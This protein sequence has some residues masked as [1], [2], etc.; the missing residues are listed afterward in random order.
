MDLLCRP[1]GKCAIY[2][3]SFLGKPLLDCGGLNDDAFE[4]LGM[5]LPFNLCRRYTNSSY[6]LE[7]L[8]LGQA[9]FLEPGFQDE[10][11]AGLREEYQYLRNMHSLTPMN[12]VSWKFFRIRPAAFPTIRILQ[13]V[14]M[15]GKHQSLVNGVLLEEDVSRIMGL[16]RNVISEYWTTH[17]LPDRCSEAS[18]RICS[19]SFTRVWM[20]NSKFPLAI[21]YG[22]KKFQEERVERAIQAMESFLPEKNKVI[23]AW[24]GVGIR[25]GNALESQGLLHLK[26]KYCD[27]KKCVNCS[28]G[29]YLLSH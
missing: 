21:F 1:T 18:D 19:E 6:Q 15:L 8:A 4:Q 28:I 10:Y 25:A 13:W 22:K 26:K 16:F 23:S 27:F 9:G 14:A 2:S 11:P 20:I 29:V 17:L 12:R 5:V 24:A 7:A 3:G